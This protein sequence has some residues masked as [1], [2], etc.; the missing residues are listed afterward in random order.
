M[1]ETAMGVLKV[2][3]HRAKGLRNAERF[4]TSDPYC[5]LSILGTKELARTKTADDTLTPIWNETFYLLLNSLTDNLK[6]EVYDSNVSKDKL[7]GASTFPLQT[8]AEKPIQEE[9]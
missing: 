5:S 7:M 3:I 1:K 6:I 4:G 2:T 9:V 8:L